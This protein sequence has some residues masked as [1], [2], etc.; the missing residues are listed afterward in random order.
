MIQDWT[1]IRRYL[2][3]WAGA[4]GALTFYFA[5]MRLSCGLGHCGDQGLA[6]ANLV[7]LAAMIV[8]CLRSAL[9]LTRVE[10]RLLFTPL[11]AYG[12]SSALFFGFGPMSA[13]LANDATQYFLARSVYAVSGQDVLR[14]GLLTSLGICVSLFA[15]LAV[16]PR[17]M[18]RVL[19]RRELS[20]KTVAL[21]FLA[22]GL[23]L[24]H[25]LI[26][27]SIYGVSD[28]FVPGV[29]RNLRYLP[30]LGFA[31]MAMVAA[32]GDR[33]WR[34]LFWLIWPWHFL[35]AFPE[36]SKK[37]VMLTMLLPALGAYLGHR[38]W[39]FFALWVVAAMAI[40][41]ALQNINAV[42]RWTENDRQYEVL[43]VRERLALLSDIA[44]S[45]VEIEA[46]LPDRRIGVDTWWLRLNYSGPQTAAMD[47]YDT[48]LSSGFTQNP[49]IYVVPRF[50]WPE[51]PELI[52]PGLQFHATV[53]GNTETR[54]RVGV[55]VFADGYRQMGW[56]G[57]VIFAAVMG[58]IMGGIARM[59]MAQIGQQQFLYL[60]A[61]MIGIQ[62]GATSTT[63]FLQ[64]GFVAAMPV[65]FGYCGVVAVA[66]YILQEMQRAQAEAAGLPPQS[67][68]SQG[69][70]GARP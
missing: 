39:R 37:S 54:T 36:F 65:Y 1:L 55:T 63:A 16:L 41:T 15:I 60:P 22:T 47:L 5:F 48:G 58:A 42:A 6:A 31:L 21:M 50:L 33:R 27:P 53:T 18:R 25:L 66:Y 11:V 3:Q 59:T 19:P 35:L 8:I 52:S 26:M 20:L 12:A 57:V 45:D 51:K 44:L 49:L 9:M 2:W 29:L 28:I 38:S 24:K 4:M 40:F 43:G 46:Y 64:N 56:P 68:A 23:A 17:G 7:G 69:Y 30:D 61:A 14:T 10:T 67:V 34:L 13:F 32:S 70:Y 62:M